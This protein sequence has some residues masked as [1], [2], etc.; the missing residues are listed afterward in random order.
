MLPNDE[1][2]QARYTFN[3]WK[4]NPSKGEVFTPNGLVNEMLNQ[5][6]T[7]IWENPKST[8]CDPFMGKGTFLVEI[9]RRLVYIYCYK[10]ED[11]KSR[12]FGYEVRV[13]YVNY[14]KRNPQYDPLFVRVNAIKQID[15]NDYYLME[16]II[17]V[18]FALS[19]M[20]LLS[21]INCNDQKNINNENIN[22][23][24]LKNKIKLILFC[25]VK[26]HIWC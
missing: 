1:F 17:I 5:I 20:V 13:K 9:V 14:L 19:M 18:V 2:L 10:E 16:Y 6:P 25:C 12:V 7:E 26:G 8:F 4:Q 21:K 15:N 24:N 11:A 22:Q 3:K 23:D